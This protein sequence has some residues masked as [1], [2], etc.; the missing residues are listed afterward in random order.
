MDELNLLRRGMLHKQAE[1][2]CSSDSSIPLGGPPGQA[3]DVTITLHREEAAASGLLLRAW[4]REAQE[5][6]P[7]AEA[8]QINWEKGLLQVRQLSYLFLA[9]LASLSSRQ[10]PRQ[11]SVLP[12]LAASTATMGCTQNVPSACCHYFCG[13]L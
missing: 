7:C 2:L 3:L 4:L 6:V 10:S 8:L 13:L 9:L 11:S 5:G 1:A 12:L